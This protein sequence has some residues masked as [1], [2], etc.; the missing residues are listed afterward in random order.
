MVNTKGIPISVRLLLT[1]N[2]NKKGGLREAN[3]LKKRRNGLEISDFKS[4][5]SDCQWQL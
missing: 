5:T 3:L 4:Q 2:S 1:A